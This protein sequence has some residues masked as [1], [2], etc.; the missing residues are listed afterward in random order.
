[1]EIVISYSNEQGM[2][3]LEELVESLMT[4]YGATSFSTGVAGGAGFEDEHLVPPIFSHH[5]SFNEGTLEF[6]YSHSFNLLL[7]EFLWQ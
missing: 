2:L 1:M 6:D 7:T 5:I 4:K 3:E